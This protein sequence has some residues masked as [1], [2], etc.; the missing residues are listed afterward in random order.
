MRE[1]SSVYVMTLKILQRRNHLSSSALGNLAGIGAVISRWEKFRFNPFPSEQELRA[2]GELLGLD[3][4]QL[5]LMLPPLGVGMKSEP[6]RLCGACYG[7]SPCHQIKWQFKTTGG[8]DKHQLRLLSKCPRC[9]KRFNF[10]SLWEF[11][12]CDL[13]KRGTA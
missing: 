12:Q 2:L 8:C 4:A 11:G 10:P 9:G 7:E 6:I 1:K 13:A 3:L 5:Q